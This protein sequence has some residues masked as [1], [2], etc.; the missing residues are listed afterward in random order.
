M[1]NVNGHEPGTS[2]DV[3]DVQEQA[4][5]AAYLEAAQQTRNRIVDELRGLRDSEQRLVDEF[6]RQAGEAR[7]RVS[8]YQ[9]ALDALGSRK[10]TAPAKPA[11]AKQAAKRGGGKQWRVSDLKVEEVRQRIVALMPDSPHKVGE[12]PV[13]TISY[14]ADNSEGIS[15]ESVEQAMNA[16]REREVVRI[17]GTGRGGG[18]LFAL[19]P[20]GT[21]D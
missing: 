19:M 12:V 20:E 4:P 3:I 11:P 16:L 17:A 5:I 6:T 14:V 15:R 9:R 8:N 1:D 2:L 13:V 18:K 10:R 7:A 21:D